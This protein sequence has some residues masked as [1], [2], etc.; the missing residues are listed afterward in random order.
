MR[1]P[2][3]PRGTLGR[4]RPHPPPAGLSPA[5]RALSA[6]PPH[7]DHS[8]DPPCRYPTHPDP[9]LLPS[10]VYLA[11]PL[12]R[13]HG[14]SPGITYFACA[15]T[16][17]PIHPRS[18]TLCPDSPAFHALTSR[19]IPPRRSPTHPRSLHTVLCSPSSSLGRPASPTSPA[20]CLP[21]SA[22]A[23]PTSS[24]PSATQTSPPYGCASHPCPPN[25]PSFR[26]SSPR[27]SWT[28]TFSSPH[29]PRHC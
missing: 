26:S 6:P 5:I 25:F 22:P 8:T 23:P 14:P 10:A 21:R 11:C 17:R 19:P 16:S 29:I 3:T 27:S 2:S 15:P 18:R 1:A 7:L 9:R 20:P 4:P 28:F 12:E 24:T 13:R